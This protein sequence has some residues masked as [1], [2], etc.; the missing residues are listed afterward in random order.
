MPISPLRRGRV[1]NLTSC[2]SI[3]QQHRR[4]DSSSTDTQQTLT[5]GSLL[6]MPLCRTTIYPFRTNMKGSEL[7]KTIGGYRTEQ[8]RRLLVEMYRAMPKRVKEDHGID[9]MIFLPRMS[10]RIW[11][12]FWIPYCSLWQGASGRGPTS[13]VQ[14]DSESNLYR[15]RSC[16]AVRS[17]ARYLIPIARSFRNLQLCSSC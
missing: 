8:L 12:A 15:R 4:S 5:L 17:T 10:A 2:R 6:R 14:Q 1:F 3:R 7:K 11:M 9:D 16:G 13:C